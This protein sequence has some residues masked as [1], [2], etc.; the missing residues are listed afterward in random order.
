MPTTLARKINYLATV[1]DL[2][3]QIQVCFLVTVG[4]SR[5]MSINN[6]K[7]NIFHRMEWHPAGLLVCLPQIS[8][9]APQRPEEDFFW[10]W[11]TQVVQER[12]P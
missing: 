9:P 11:P 8:P 12:G 2:W 10:H 4:L 6:Q 1:T 5:L 3:L 7:R